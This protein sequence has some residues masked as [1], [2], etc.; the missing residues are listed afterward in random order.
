MPLTA[1]ERALSKK[2]TLE[3]YMTSMSL[4][5]AIA[6]SLEDDRFRQ[7]SIDR[8]VANER[9]RSPGSARAFAESRWELVDALIYRTME[10][11]RRLKEAGVDES[12][13]VSLRQ[14]AKQ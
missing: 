10:R 11:S 6:R 7:A 9:S 8:D 2:R 4:S 13:F 3:L 1:A 5:K 14:H 12:P